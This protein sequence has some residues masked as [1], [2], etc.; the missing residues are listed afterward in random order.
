MTRPTPR[1]D[2]SSIP[3][4]QGFVT[5]QI[6]EEATVSAIA[7]RLRLAEGQS[8]ALLQLDSELGVRSGG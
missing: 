8:G 4:L 2:I 3:F 1:D 6:E 7:D 5:E